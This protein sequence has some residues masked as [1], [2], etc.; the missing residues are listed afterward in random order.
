MSLLSGASWRRY[1]RRDGAPLPAGHSIAGWTASGGRGGVP[2]ADA[3]A[4]RGDA[5]G[6]DD[7]RA[8]PG[9]RRGG[10]TGSVAG[11]PEGNRLVRGAPVAQDLAVSPRGGHHPNEGGPPSAPR[12][13]L[14]AGR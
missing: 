3:R 2:R 14:L 7:V 1:S 6:R 9:D 8:E 11:R 5:A 10:R 13:L 12:G 4:R